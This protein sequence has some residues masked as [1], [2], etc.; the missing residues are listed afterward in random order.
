[1]DAGGDKKLPYLPEGDSSP[2]L[3]SHGIRFSLEHPEIFLTQLRAALRADLGLENLR[4]LLPMITDLDELE[5]AMALI[6]QAVGQLADEGFAVSRPPVGAM[7][8]VPAA[9]YEAERLA[10]RADFL[11]VGSNDL[12]QYLLATDRNNPRDSTRLGLAHPALLK[13]LQQVVE[14]AHQAAKTVTICGEIAS[15]PAMALLLLGMGFDA[16]SVSPAALPRVKW[17]VR[18]SNLARMHSLAAEALQCQTS[19]AHSDLLDRIR[20]E[21]GL[22]GTTN[23]SSAPPE[24]SAAAMVQQHATTPG[25]ARP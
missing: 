20:L 11:S 13:A 5:R 7:I 10:R 19:G 21:I 25:A 18:G 2:A 12:A 16:L 22:Q 4:L 6:E 14:S 17:A 8:E 9:V 1:L 23:P 3:G 24:V 15:D